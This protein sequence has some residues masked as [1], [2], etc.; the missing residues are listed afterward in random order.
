MRIR[1]PT[2][3]YASPSRQSLVALAASTGAGAVQQGIGAQQQGQSDPA[4]QSRDRSRT[5]SEGAPSPA[6][7]DPDRLRKLTAPR[8]SGPGGLLNG[9]ANELEE[10]EDAGENGDEIGG[11]PQ[12]HLGDLLLRPPGARQAALSG[13]P[14]GGAASDDEAD[15]NR[16]AARVDKGKGRFVSPRDLQQARAQGASDDDEDLSPPSNTLK[17]FGNGNGFMAGATSLSALGGAVDEND[18][19]M[20]DEE[21]DA[22][23]MYPTSAQQT[24][25]SRAATAPPA[26]LGFSRTI[27]KSDP[28]LFAHASQANDR[29]LADAEVDM[30]ASD[31]DQLEY[32]DAVPSKKAKQP[33]RRPRA[34]KKKAVEVNP[35]DEEDELASQDGTGAAAAGGD[36]ASNGDIDGAGRPRRQSKLDAASKLGAL[37]WS[38]RV[39]KKSTQAPAAAGKNGG[40]ASSTQPAPAKKKGKRV[41]RAY[42]SSEDEAEERKPAKKSKPSVPSLPRRSIDLALTDARASAAQKGK[43]RAATSPARSDSDEPEQTQRKSKR[44]RPAV[45]PAGTERKGAKAGSSKV[46][47]TRA[48][49]QKDANVEASQAKLRASSVAASQAKKPKVEPR[50]RREGTRRSSRASLQSGMVAGSQRMTPD[51]GFKP[52]EIGYVENQTMQPVLARLGEF[53]RSRRHA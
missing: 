37:D 9:Y 10:G 28:G 48:L 16:T 17:A 49:K 7:N 14:T 31:E 19:E 33:I 34:G 47:S 1:S 53:P 50:E 12:S 35:D 29:G 36:D 41:T 44:S 26:R 25:P 51:G 8:S 6:R 27:H 5:R 21:A 43:R 46:K 13:L 15:E 22:F 20:E 45:K 2:N 40:R 32:A 30:L 42:T 18:A 23:L 24:G 3:P 4:L 39:P 11:P 52:G 38:K